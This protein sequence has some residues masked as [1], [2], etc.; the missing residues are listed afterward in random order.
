MTLPFLECQPAQ[1]EVKKK[2][3]TKEDIDQ[4]FDISMVKHKGQ[5]LLLDHTHIFLW[6]DVGR[7]K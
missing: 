1:E 7:T 2:E 6:F 5:V 3:L 4:R